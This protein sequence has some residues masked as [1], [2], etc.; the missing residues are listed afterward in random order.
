[1]GCASSVPEEDNGEA[2]FEG[3]DVTHTFSPPKAWKHEKIIGPTKLAKLRDDFWECQPH[4]G[5]KKEIWEAL[6]A[7]C[8]CMLTGDMTMART[9]VEASGIRV[10]RPD[11]TCVYDSL[12]NKY[13]LPKYLMSKPSNLVSDEKCPPDSPRGPLP[14]GAGGFTLS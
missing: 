1:M 3:G 10:V 13:D 8:E 5:G 12:G 2:Q 11:F 9:I 14:P 6:K 4:Y 7:S